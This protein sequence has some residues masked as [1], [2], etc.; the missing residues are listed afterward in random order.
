MSY[1][2]LP[3]PNP[4]SQVTSPVTQP[5][6]S[7]SQQ[8]Q[9]PLTPPQQQT[10][11]DLPQELSSP[12]SPL[13]LSLHPSSAAVS[14]SSASPI[15]VNSTG[16]TLSGHSHPTINTAILPPYG[17]M[18]PSPQHSSLAT[19]TVGSLLPGTPPQLPQL[20]DLETIL[21][22]YGNQ[23]ELLKLII[24]SKT[25]ED[26]R[27]AEEARYRM[28]DLVVQGENRGLLMTDYDSFLNPPVPGAPTAGT[29][30]SSINSP[31]IASTPVP[32]PVTSAPATTV[33]AT[34]TAAATTSLG[35]NQ[36]GKRFIDD[37]VDPYP[38]ASTGNN[39]GGL[40]NFQD[41][42]LARKRS[43]TFARD[44]HHGHL[45]S[46]S[47]SSMPTVSSLMSPGDQFGISM[48]G[49]GTS[50]AGLQHPQHPHSQHPHQPPQHPHSQAQHSPLHQLPPL[51]LNHSY[52]QSPQ[53]QH[54]QSPVQ[55]SPHQQ[56][57]PQYPQVFHNM[58]QFHPHLIRRTNSLSHIPHF[59]TQ[60]QNGVDRYRR[61]ESESG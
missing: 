45:R 16:A 10:S 41:H 25:E 33:A 48:M 43:V 35:L 15:S 60:H 27:R 13:P 54:F 1:M 24:A 23:P 56:L 44:V 40:S 58:P 2:Y 49:L 51:T 6:Q 32:V 29:P 28:L 47:M 57:P 14:V 8:S 36:S 18:L 9:Q 55:Q 26:R 3:Y 42:G 53:N 46:Q 38:G 17:G 39:S 59:P 22:T 19:P 34:A 37:A 50:S 5:Q 52:Q 4:P 7:Q 31:S 12:T 30:P 11:Q 61:N 20:G 21:A